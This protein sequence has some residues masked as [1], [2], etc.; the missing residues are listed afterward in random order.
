MA[1]MEIER[2]NLMSRNLMIICLVCIVLILQADAK[3]PDK[4][5]AIFG[6]AELDFSVGEYTFPI[7]E[8]KPLGNEISQEIEEIQVPDTVKIYELVTFDQTKINNDIRSLA[9][10]LSFRINGTE[11]YTHLTRMD[12]DTLDDGIDSYSGTLIG[13]DNSSVLLTVNDDIMIGSI[14]LDDETY[15]IEPVNLLLTNP[16]S[17]D[18]RTHIIYRSGDIEG[19]EF[20]FENG[21]TGVPRQQNIIESGTRSSHAIESLPDGRT[22]ITILIVTDNQFYTDTGGT[23]W[24]VVAQDIIAEANRQLGRNDIGVILVPQYDDARRQDLSNYE[25]HNTKPLVTFDAFY[26]DDVLNARSADLGLYIGGY[27]CIGSDGDA[28]GLSYIYGNSTLPTYGRRAWAQMVPD[29]SLGAYFGSLAGRRSI[30]IHE[31]GHML[32]AGHE[33]SNDPPYY[34]RAASWNL[35]AY[36]TVMWSTYIEGVNTCEFSSVAYHGDTTR[37]NAKRIKEETKGIV[38]GY[39]GC[40]ASPPSA[41]FYWRPDISPLYTGQIIRFIPTNRLNNPTYYYWDLGDGTGSSDIEPEWVYAVATDY[42][43]KLTVANCA[44]SSITE[45]TV[46]I[47]QSPHQVSFVGNPL[48]GNAPLNVHFNGSATPPPDSWNWNFGDGYSSTE[49]NP[50]HIYYES[51]SYTVILTVEQNGNSSSKILPDYINVA[52]QPPHADFSTNPTRYGTTPATV[53][54][55]DTSTNDPDEWSWNFGD[56]DGTNASKKDPVHTYR[57]NGTY[58]V[59]LTATNSATG[60]NTTTK[61]N[62]IT[63]GP[64]YATTNGA[65]TVLKFNSTGSTKWTPPHGVTAVDYLVVGGGGQGGIGAAYTYNGHSYFISGGGGGAGGLLNGS[66]RP[67]VGIQTIVVGAGGSGSASACGAKGGDSSFGNATF[68]IFAHGGGGGAGGGNYC[69]A[70]KNGGSGGGG[71]GDW[72][73]NPNGTGIVPEG[74]GG[75]AGYLNSGLYRG[76]GGGGGSVAAKGSAANSTSGGD[77]GNGKSIDI[78]GIVTIYA[79]GGGGGSAM[80]G[81]TAGSGGIGC[82]GDGSKGYPNSAKCEE[83]GAGG[84]GTSNTARGSG[85]SS[86]AGGSGIVIIRYL[87]P[88]EMPA[89]GDSFNPSISADGRYVAFDSDATNL[90]SDDTNEVTD[91][92]V[93]DRQTETTYRISKSTGGIEGDGGSGLPSISS[94]GMNATFESGATNLVS[95]DTNGKRDIFVRNRASGTTYLISKDSTGTIGNGDS[96]NPSISADGMYATFESVA[97][98]LVSGDTNGKRDIFVRN[99]ATGATYLISR[100]S[101]GTIGNGDSANPSISADGLYAAFESVATNLV[102]GDTNAK[103][104]VFVRDRAAGTTNLISKSS[105]GI[106]GNDASYDPSISVDGRNVTFESIA[107]NL[108]TDDTNGMRDIFVRDRQSGTTYR[109]SKNTTGGEAN[110]NSYNSSIAADGRYVTFESLASNLVTDDTNE[111]KDIFVR[112]RAAGVTYL[113]SRSSAGTIGNGGSRNPSI[114]ADGRYVTF[115]SVATN[116][117]DGDTNGKSDI[118]V[119]DRQTG[120]TTLVSKN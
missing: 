29:Y 100:D 113:I 26:D 48:T 18:F 57:G 46:T 19:R 54:F 32:G 30:S 112:D 22:V 55:T 35:G 66:A 28:Q 73:L 118:F 1:V 17:K 6:N 12:F 91:I 2:G 40:S 80:E 85:S 62:Y 11:Y 92:F 75:G 21:I 104:D 88:T 116:L 106:V 23:G 105:A 115:E 25:Y 70:T 16:A 63:V 99:R 51:G 81:T 3:L 65:Y 84:G 76:D 41:D 79:G 68:N 58:T 24:I 14:T 117:V 20:S 13:K 56:G 5:Q 49:Q 53:T 82:G 47:A 94:D 69:D 93:H 74:Y 34:N 101:T 9:H 87:T 107:T 110:N 77:G 97:T 72:F 78:T 108:V 7:R 31:I 8:S 96:V 109:V 27:D 83:T 64:L 37:N 89:D 102:S 103:R 67:V 95:G 111:I 119:R 60:S 10:N 4:D 86:G 120:T 71:T 45:H 50:E 36:R 42:H 59:S 61:T 98:N 44:G 114:S 90:V 43:V 15:Y 39:A 33:D 38:A 52:P